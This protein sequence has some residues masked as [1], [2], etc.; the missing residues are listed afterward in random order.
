MGKIAVKTTGTTISVGN[1]DQIDMNIPGGGVVTIVAQNSNVNKLTINFLDDNESDKAIIDLSSFAQN[2]LRI[3]LKKYDPTDALTLQ[4]AYDTHVDPSNPDVM[5]FKY[6]G[7]DGLEHTGYARLMDG[8]EKNF[9]TN[10]SPII[11]CFARGSMI[12]T[13]RGQVAVETLRVGDL[14]ITADNGLQA[15]RWIG[16]KVMTGA[17]L[18]AYPELR[19]IRIRR[20]AFGKGLPERDLWVS[21]QHR[22]LL[23]SAQAQLRFGESEVL[24]P[25]KALL[26][27]RRITRDYGIRQTEYFHIMFDHHEIVFSEGMPTESFFP[28]KQALKGVQD[29]A[30]DELFKIFPELTDH[31]DTFGST[32]R[33]NLRVQDAKRII[34]PH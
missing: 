8:G 17:R 20:G 12:T 34:W 15:I 28:G 3:D 13:P 26:D 29:E 27:D 31:P 1:N 16:S 24:V 23:R 14:V 2:G 19:P 4:G 6:I 33:L 5:T 25:A 11:I 18:Q 30:R 9:L 21:P 10:P 7:S 22:I 32:A